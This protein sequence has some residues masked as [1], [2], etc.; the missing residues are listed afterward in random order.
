MAERVVVYATTSLMEADFV[1][2]ALEDHGVDCVVENE[3]MAR[4]ALGA[5]PLVLS[6]PEKQ[7]EPARQLV[8]AALRTMKL[9]ASEGPVPMQAVRCGC[10][11]ELEV[12]E[13]AEAQKIECPYCGGVVEIG[14]TDSP[15]AQPRG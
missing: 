15:G 10:G 7:A 11:R 1:R 12:P 9:P 3:S 4:Y 2:V 13:G 14:G 5:V 6:V 8:A